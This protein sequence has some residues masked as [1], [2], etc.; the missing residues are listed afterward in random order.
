MRPVD[1]LQNG[2]FVVA[3][4][5]TYSLTR[6]VVLSAAIMSLALPISLALLLL[7]CGSAP[8]LV[9]ASFAAC[10]TGDAACVGGTSDGTYCCPSLWALNTGTAAASCSSFTTPP[11]TLA[12]CA[13]TG[14][15]LP[16]LQP[17]SSAQ[18][19]CAYPGTTGCAS[20]SIA[21]GSTGSPNF[22][23]SGMGYT[24]CAAGQQPLVTSL[25]IV[26]TTGG[27]GL[28]AR[29]VDYTT[30][31]S[32]S[33]VPAQTTT[34]CY[35]LP[36]AYQFKYGTKGIVWSCSG[37]SACTGTVQSTVTCVTPPSGTQCLAGPAPGTAG[38]QS[39]LGFT[40]PCAS[41]PTAVTGNDNTQ[42]CCSDTTSQPTWGQAGY[43]T[44]PCT[45][46]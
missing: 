16:I 38:T 17:C 37:A 20:F 1:V 34:S 42:Y 39:P 3:C 27:S 30:P 10:L 19:A 44:C 14:Q 13:A 9:D 29:L 7:A 24:A 31:N 11:P 8:T 26:A 2:V 15:G 21:S 45:S 22:S 6:S 41:N 40:S 46:N 12:G 28:L 23:P 32:V 43:C 33:L 18:S 4:L 25:Q 36:L 5:L 35:T